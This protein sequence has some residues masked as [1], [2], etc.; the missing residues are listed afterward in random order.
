MS[1]TFW[2]PIEPWW[3]WEYPDQAK[4]GSGTEL[5]FL[6]HLSVDFSNKSSVPNNRHTI[7]VLIPDEPERKLWLH[8][9]IY[10]HF[11][12]NSIPCAPRSLWPWSEWKIIIRHHWKNSKV[13]RIIQVNSK[14]TVI[15][16]NYD[17]QIERGFKFNIFFTLQ[18]VTSP[19]VEHPR[20]WQIRFYKMPPPLPKLTHVNYNLIK[21]HTKQSGLQFPIH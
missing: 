6:S 9:I 12:L 10:K 19:I 13:N 18:S 15:K 4:S 3:S 8:F 1:L 14:C 16:T 7:Y 21:N 5:R 2:S 17:W 11:F 20:N